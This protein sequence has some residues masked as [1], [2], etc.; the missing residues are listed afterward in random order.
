MKQCAVLLVYLLL[1]F[2]FRNR[3][4][5]ASGSFLCVARVVWGIRVT[6]HLTGHEWKW[7]AGSGMTVFVTDCV[8]FMGRL[9]TLKFVE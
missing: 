6:S 8:F 4:R 2:C 5:C 3:F 7:Q 1:F 9:Q